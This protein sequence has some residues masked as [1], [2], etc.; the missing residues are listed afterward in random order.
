MLAVV[1]VGVEVAVL[2]E[3][4]VVPEDVVELEEVVEELVGVDVAVV[5]VDGVEE[6]AGARTVTTREALP[7]SPAESVTR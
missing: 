7:V 5:L 2:P 6:A 4:T 1:V 3:L